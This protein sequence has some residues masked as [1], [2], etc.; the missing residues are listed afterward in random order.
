MN[1]QGLIMIFIYRGIHLFFLFFKKGY[2]QAGPAPDYFAPLA[3]AITCIPP[4]LKKKASFNSNQINKMVMN[5]QPLTIMNNYCIFLSLC[6]S[7]KQF[8]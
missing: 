7:L 8:V 1:I 3:K 4:C 6:F 5:N 2:R